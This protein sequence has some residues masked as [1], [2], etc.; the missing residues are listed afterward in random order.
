MRAC[1]SA[2]AASI[3]SRASRGSLCKTGFA[4]K[5]SPFLRL[6]FRDFR[7]EI[8]VWFFLSGSNLESI[9]RYK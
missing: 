5:N 6:T 1:D 8:F 9:G 3:G 2:L 7:E 4:G